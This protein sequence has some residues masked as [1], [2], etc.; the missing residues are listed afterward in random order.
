MRVVLMR[1]LRNVVWRWYGRAG[2]F[3]ISRALLL[4]PCRA[5][6]NILDFTSA[7][8]KRELEHAR[9]RA[10]ARSQALQLHLRRI[11]EPDPSE[12]VFDAHRLA[13]DALPGR[14]V[15]SDDRVSAIG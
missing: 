15:R 10:R 1:R 9:D 8:L 6:S 7:R 13:G 11:E 2:W 14:D 12:D 3:V 5:A 4:C